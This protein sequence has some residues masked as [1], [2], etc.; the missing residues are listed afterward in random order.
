MPTG[1]SRPLTQRAWRT[2]AKGMSVRFLAPSELAPQLSDADLFVN[3]YGSAFPVEAWPAILAYLEGGGN[4]LNWGGV[5]FRTPVAGSSTT[6]WRVQRSCTNYHREIGVVQ[7]YSYSVDEQNRTVSSHPRLDA[8]VKDSALVCPDTYPLTV[9]L[10]R[11]DREGDTDSDTGFTSPRDADYRG[12]VHSVDENSIPVAAPIT[13]MDRLLGP[14]AGGRWIFVAMNLRQLADQQIRDWL[15]LLPTLLSMTAEG[16]TN[17][18]VL[19]M[20]ACYLPGETPSLRICVRSWRDPDS[21]LSV[22]ITVTPPTGRAKRIT[23]KVAPGPGIHR[24]ELP[25]RL[26][27]EPGFYSVQAALCR[28][29]ETIEEAISAFWGRDEKL[30]S[31]GKPFTTDKDMIRRG[32]EVYPLIGASYLSSE[33]HR[34]FLWWANPGIWDRDF[35]EMAAAGTRVVRTGIW[36][37]HRY[38]MPEPGLWREDALRALDAFILSAQR[39]EIPVIFTFFAF[40]PPDYGGESPYLDPRSLSAQEEFVR[41]VVAR[42]KNCPGLIWDWIN[43]PSAMTPGTL[44]R[45]RPSGDQWEAQAWRDWLR[46]RH[47]DIDSL[48]EAW[49]VRSDEVP[50]FEEA[51]VPTE[52]DFVQEKDFLRGRRP[53]RVPDFHLFSQ[54]MFTNWALRLRTVCRSTGSKHLVTVGQDEGGCFG[55]PSPMFHAEAVDFTSVHTW[56]QNDTL[57]WD[58]IVTKVRGVPNVVEE[59]GV[60]YIE[61]LNGEPWRTENRCAALLERKYLYSLAAACAGTIHWVWNSHTLVPD[62]NEAS[63][64]LTRA[65]GT[66]KPEYEVH[67]RMTRFWWENRQHWAGRNEDPIVLILPTSFQF[68]VHTKGIKATRRAVKVLTK[69]LHMGVQ[70]VSEEDLSRLGQPKMVILPSPGC[71]SEQAWKTLLAFAEGGGTLLLSG[72]VERDPYQRITSRLGEA[73]IP[74]LGPIPIAFQELLFMSG[75]QYLLTYSDLKQHWLEREAWTGEAIVWE[76]HVGQGNILYSPL[77]LELADQFAPVVHFYSRGMEL[78]G[79]EPVL[80][81]DDYIPTTFVRLIRYR[82]AD[83]LVAVNEANDPV[84]MNFAIR[85]IGKSRRIELAAQRGGAFLI[86]RKKRILIDQY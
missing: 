35:A 26:S 71:L 43:E 32:G 22:H 56:W 38:L 19:P 7:S 57:L 42:Y 40:T 1:F 48:R 78:A 11:C 36:G 29:K 47:G 67:R 61:N 60:M 74:G 4:F 80:I 21:N 16:A 73:G 33:S 17:L 77:P 86:H 85:D 27:C 24:I 83:L 52:E 25:L 82:E 14:Y 37:G 23:R 65:D 72:V 6:G 10:T 58:G 3:P 18:E 68:S 75:D 55:R 5:P 81:I 30:L 12:L 79:I 20:L 54:Q 84:A 15:G 59:T 63:I 51:P 28:D 64:G 34:K 41:I 39:H 76:A 53:L 50:S 8:L 46:K 44:W 70:A 2:A 66:K 13:R 49:H 9:R 31:Q 62:D 69:A 45:T